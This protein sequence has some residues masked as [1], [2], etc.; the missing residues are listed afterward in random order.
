MQHDSP[1]HVP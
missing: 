1:Q